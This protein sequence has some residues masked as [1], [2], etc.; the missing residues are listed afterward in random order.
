MS[1]E[2]P[3]ADVV[4][5]PVRM[6]I[7][8]QLGGRSMTTSQLRDALPDIKQATLYRH[9]A[10]LLDA[11]ILTVTE[12]RQIRGAVE[13]TLTLGDRLAHVD[14]A[15]LEAMDA[16]QLRS[17]FAM[18]LSGLSHDFERLVDH[19]RVELRK[20]LGFARAPLYADT[21][22]LEKL[23]SDLMAVLTP[24]LEPRRDGQR[25]ITLATVLIPETDEEDQK[26]RG[27][28]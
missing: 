16:M 20:L 28:E 13:R 27:T 6:R 11:D 12:E 14:Q 3:I 15:E 18:F 7:I 9:V 1:E 17:A 26:S 8:Q 5:H 24:Y 19:E 2:A 10:A 23:Q 22:D 25:R 21:Q 4:L